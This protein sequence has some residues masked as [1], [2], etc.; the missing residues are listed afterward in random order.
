MEELDDSWID[1]FEKNENKYKT[2][3]KEDNHF[4]KI[5]YIYMNH[6][7][8]IEKIKEEKIELKKA[9]ILSR[10]EIISLIKH[11]NVD[12]YNKYSLFSILKYNIHL[13]PSDLKTFIKSK[14]TSLNSTPFSF[15]TSIVNIDTI[16]FEPTIYMFQ[17]LNELLFLFW[18]P[19]ANL[20]KTKRIF[21]HTK[22]KNKTVKHF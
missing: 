10:E 3:Y 16:F 12:N 5:H 17:D 13:D 1:E 9:N 20:N 11:N 18:K 21:I 2:F 6:D 4:I 15:L 8:I 19:N 14:Q 7:F 22:N